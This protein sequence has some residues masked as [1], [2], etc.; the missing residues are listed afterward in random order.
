MPLR[1]KHCG[2]RTLTLTLIGRNAKKQESGTKWVTAI[3]RTLTQGLLAMK[4]EEPVEGAASVEESALV[5]ES[6]RGGDSKP[7]EDAAP[8]CP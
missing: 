2:T 1:R 7:T 8:M 6:A 5:E 4:P 3:I